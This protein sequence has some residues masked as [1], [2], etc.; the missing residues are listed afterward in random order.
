[1]LLWH[2]QSGSPDAQY[3]NMQ[4]DKYGYAP[5]VTS[6]QELSA[7]GWN[8][9]YEVVDGL[10]VARTLYPDHFGLWLNP[11]APGGGVGIPWL[12]LRR[13]AT[14]LERQPAGPCGCRNRAS[15]SRSSTP[16][17]RRTPTAPRR[18]AHCAAP[19]SSPRSERRIS[20]S[21]WTSTTP[22]RPP[23]TRCAA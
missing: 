5:C 14:G 12:D 17:S 3:G 8:R 10:D 1:M 6:A 23:W 7:S 11:H 4:V 19:G 15:R 13:I 18:S 22:V 9:S 20:R 21:A 2:G 16:R